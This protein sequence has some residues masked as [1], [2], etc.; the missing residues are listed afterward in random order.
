MS[1]TPLTDRRLGSV[2]AMRRAVVILL[3]SV[4]GAGVLAGILLLLRP[5]GGALGL[6]LA[7]LPEWYSGSFFGAGVL[8]LTGFATA[9]VVAIVLMYV[10]PTA[11]WYAAIF[12]GAGLVIWMMVQIGLVGFILLSVQLGFIA[13]GI[14]LMAIGVVHARRIRAEAADDASTSGIPSSNGP[15]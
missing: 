10:R 4:S 11:G 13:I 8:L 14:A 3:A 15:V 5:D 1:S 12:L 2:E 9:P 6:S 7:L